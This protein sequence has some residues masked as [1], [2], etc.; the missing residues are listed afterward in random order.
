MSVRHD[1]MWCTLVHLGTNFW[2]DEGNNRGDGG[3]H[4]GRKTY[5]EPASPDMRFDQATWE[6]YLKRMKEGGINTIMLD[7]GDGM[8]YRS[9]P[10][11]AANGAWTREQMEAEAK[12]LEEMGFEVIPKLN[13]SATHDVW[14]KDYGRMLSTPIYYQVCKDLIDEVCEIFKP[15]YFHI[16]MDEETYDMQEQYDFVVLRQHDLWW[17]DLYYLVDCVEQNGARAMMWCDYARHK[18]EEFVEK[19]PKSVIPC[20]WYYFDYYGDDIPELYRIR[21]NPFHI[22]EEHGFDQFPIGSVECVL[23]CVQPLTKYCTK[24]ISKEHLLG[25][26]Q[27]TWVSCTPE[28]EQVLDNGI[29]TM[30]EARDWYENQK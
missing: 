3:P 19:C 10:E 2:Y 6:S 13:F 25:I 23:N 8:V 17:H 9:H 28:W 20:N 30:T 11:I 21:V 15:R 16:G 4:P 5:K 14:M 1:F 24:H 7:I 26:G 29:K 12:R 27:T 18:P 22:L